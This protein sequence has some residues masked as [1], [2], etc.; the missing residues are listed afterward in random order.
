LE[1]KTIENLPWDI[2]GERNASLL[3]YS[4]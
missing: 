4:M 2:R 1:R 3:L